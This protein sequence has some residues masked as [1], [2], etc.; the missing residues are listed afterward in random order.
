[1]NLGGALVHLHRTEMDVLVLVV[2]L[3]DKFVVVASAVGMAA[4]K[5]L[6]DRI[7]LL[8]VRH[9]PLSFAVSFAL[10]RVFDVWKPLGAHQAQRLPGGFG[11][12]A[13]DVIAGFTAC[14]AFHLAAWGFSLVTAA[15][16]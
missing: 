14:G 3:G 9:D 1:M 2:M 8:G 4:L 11:V 10:F 15:H 7:A 13:D 16:H 12:V 5:L 6:L